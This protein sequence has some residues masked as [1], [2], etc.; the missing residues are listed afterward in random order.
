MLVAIVI[1]VGCGGEKLLMQAETASAETSTILT[2]GSLIAGFMIPFAGI[3]SDV[4][5]YIS[6]DGSR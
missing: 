3:V 5:V 1:A 2:F 4:S 6:P